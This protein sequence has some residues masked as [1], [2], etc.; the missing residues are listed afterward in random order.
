MKILLIGEFSGVHN[1][2]KKSLVD[3]GHSVILAANGDGYRKFDSDFLLTPYKGRIYGRIKNII[4]LLKNINKLTGYDVVQYINPFVIPYYS[5]FFGVPLLIT[6]F[7][8]K[9]V[10]YACGTD[11]CYYELSIIL[12]TFL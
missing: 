4:Y 5:L 9:K 8:K 7:N 10:Y 3:S 1:N 6:L 11:P 12:N 2:L